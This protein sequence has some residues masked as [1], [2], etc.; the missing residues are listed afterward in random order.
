MFSHVISNYWSVPDDVHSYE[1]SLAR[2]SL[3]SLF[4]TLDIHIKNIHTPEDV[5]ETVNELSDGFLKLIDVSPRNPKI[6]ADPFL[7]AMYC[8]DVL[9]NARFSEPKT[10]KIKLAFRVQGLLRSYGHILNT[11][12]F[13]RRYEEQEQINR[14]IS[15]SMISHERLGS[16]LGP[17]RYLDN[18]IIR[19]ICKDAK[20]PH[21]TQN[22]QRR[23]ISFTKRYEYAEFVLSRFE[24][25]SRIERNRSI[26][27]I[28]LHNFTSSPY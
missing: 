14:D 24:E 28:Y 21:A 15:F 3:S 5:D 1:Y 9:S 12:E 20:I 10:I 19:K 18:E 4:E 11:S 22:E 16:Q 8:I 6:A 7:M 2:E 25:W 26:W 17:M 23:F 13:N 27:A